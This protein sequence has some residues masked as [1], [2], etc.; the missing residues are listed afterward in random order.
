MEGTNNPFFVMLNGLTQSVREICLATANQSQE[1][2]ANKFSQL[3]KHSRLSSLNSFN[4]LNRTELH[5]SFR[6]QFMQGCN[7]DYERHENPQRVVA[8]MCSGLCGGAASFL[9]HRVMIDNL[10]IRRLDEL[11]EVFSKEFVPTDH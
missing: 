1:F 6:F 7:I 4:S 10:P 2:R 11:V 8:I 9:S 3:S 5:A